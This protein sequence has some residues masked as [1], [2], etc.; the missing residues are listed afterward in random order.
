[1]RRSK[2]FSDTF[3]DAD[4]ALSPF[5][6]SRETRARLQIVVDELACWQKAKNL[7]GPSTLAQVWSRH[8][9]DS[10]QLRALAPQARRWLDLGAGAG[11]PGL[12]IAIAMMQDAPG[13]PPPIVHCIEANARKCAFI[14]HAARLTGAAVEV[15][16]ERIEA[17]ID[18]FAGRID[19][20]T[21][22]ALAPLAQLLDWTFPLLTS[23]AIGLFPK[24]DQVGAELTEARKSSTFEVEE[25][26]SATDPRGRILRIATLARN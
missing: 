4:A 11:F 1:M 7:V 13:E 5:D 2:E 15:R 21:A 16:N 9:A 3:D 10:L 12:V 18:G 25:F 8:I 17:V 23:G 14:R 24:G 26:P 6:V 22:R 20:V 19:V